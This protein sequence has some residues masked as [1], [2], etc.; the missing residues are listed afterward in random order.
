MPFPACRFNQS[1]IKGI[2]KI[3]ETEN[4][5]TINFD[6]QHLISFI[7]LL[8]TYSIPSLLLELLQ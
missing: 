4:M 8:F 5:P 3:G 7:T 2:D 6:I 1:P